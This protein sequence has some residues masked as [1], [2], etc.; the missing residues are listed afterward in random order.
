[1]IK[2]AIAYVTRKKN[3]TLI[4]FIILTVVL[5]CLYSCLSIMKSSNDLEK[6]LYQFSN[7]SLS[8]MQKDNG[9]FPI[10]QFDE[11][12]KLKEIDEIIPLY[13]GLAKP[14]KAQ[15]VEG[16][17]KIERDFLPDEFK[18]IVAV[19]ATNNTKRNILFNSGVFKIEQGRDIE[20]DDRDKILVHEAFAEKNG[21]QL[22]D[23]IAFAMIDNNNPNLNSEYEFEIVGIFS[24]KKQEKYTGLSS[25]FSENM[26]FVD[27]ESCQKALQKED[28]QVVNKLDLYSNDPQKMEQAFTRIKE[29]DL[30]WSKYDLAKDTNAFEES[31]EALGGVKHI[32]K[33]M[34]YAIMIGGLVVL[35]LILVLWL[36][37]RIYEIGILL[38]I[39]RRKIEIIMQFIL[40]LFLISL[41]AIII[42]L[43]LGN[44]LIGRLIGRLINTDGSAT[45]SQHVFE[46]G[47]G[48]AGL[49]TFLQSYGILIS[50]IILSVIL[51]GGMILIKKPKEILSKIS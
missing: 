3:R 51:A 21:L 39:G 37:E 26:V 31:L 6:S 27:Y 48:L 2:N 19:E 25:D 14:L 41:P 36:R 50:I 12:K 23:K 5:S 9:Y 30:D 15:V 29:L 49:L 18:N 40:E 4:V 17:Q 24:G 44:L 28:H 8:I 33:T 35:S 22:N 45:L 32:I 13:D 38:S 46:T 16:E 11:L 7:S 10:D 43:L 47:N 20:P 1:M 34:T 42:S